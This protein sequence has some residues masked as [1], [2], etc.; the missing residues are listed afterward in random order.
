M[1]NERGKFAPLEVLL[2]S[3]KGALIGHKNKAGLIVALSYGIN[4]TS[5][6]LTSPSLIPSPP[7]FAGVS[8]APE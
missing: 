7:A 3:D 8:F 5:V 2:T 1:Q 6:I 4:I